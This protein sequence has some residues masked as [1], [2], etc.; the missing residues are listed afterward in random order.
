MKFEREDKLAWTD[1][2]KAD[3]LYYSEQFL[4]LGEAKLEFIEIWGNY[5]YE[6]IVDS[7]EYES[8]VACVQ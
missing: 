6:R 4:T 7:P 8:N 5:E 1:K 3:Y 2:Q